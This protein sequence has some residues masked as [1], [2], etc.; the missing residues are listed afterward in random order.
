MTRS[1]VAR[2]NALT[3]RIDRLAA[4]WILG[5]QTREVVA[6][7]DLADFCKRA[8]SMCADVD[9]GIVWRNTAWNLFEVLGRPRLEDAHS[10]VIAWLMKPTAPHGL[11]DA[12]L[13]AFFEKAF[14]IAAP[15]GTL[16]CRV[17]VKRKTDNGEVDIEVKG[18]RWWLIVE[19][20]IDCEE[21]R[22]QTERYAAYYKRFAKRGERFFPVFLSREG[23][24]PESRDFAPMSYRDLRHVLES[25]CESVRPAPEVEQ[26]VRHLVK[27]ILW[28]LES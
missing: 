22:G 1:G 2:S 12:F 15:A 4:D 14:R 9:S 23:R 8:Q 19:N 21:G 5:Q 11:K 6:E 27:H 13:K 16:E 24:R 18:P 17:A 10:R 25:V 26:L 28:N 7:T 20:K 3:A